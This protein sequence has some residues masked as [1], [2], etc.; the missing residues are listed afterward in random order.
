MLAVHTWGSE[1]SMFRAKS[2]GACYP[3]PESEGNARDTWITRDSWLYSSHPAQWKIVCQKKKNSTETSATILSPFYYGRMLP[4]I[5][6]WKE[7]W[8]R[9]EPFTKWTIN[10]QDIIKHFI[11]SGGFKIFSSPYPFQETCWK[12]FSTKMRVQTKKRKTREDVV[13]HRWR[14]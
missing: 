9:A 4:Q 1:R 13:C 2:S 7:F 11:T 6:T 10:C 8:F 12:V 3:S 5:V 14:R